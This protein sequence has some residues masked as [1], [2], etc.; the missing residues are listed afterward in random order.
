MKHSVVLLLLS[1]FTGTD[2]NC[3]CKGSSMDMGNLAPRQSLDYFTDA[4]QGNPETS[5]C[6]CCG[7][8]GLFYR[9]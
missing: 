3:I 4:D 6:L 8:K 1:N 7:M 5:R 9:E 2:C